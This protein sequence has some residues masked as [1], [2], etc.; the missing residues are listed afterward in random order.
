MGSKIDG[1]GNRAYSLVYG[2]I[3]KIVK[4][5]QSNHYEKNQIMD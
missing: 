2:S 1:K 3:E 5:S 4:S